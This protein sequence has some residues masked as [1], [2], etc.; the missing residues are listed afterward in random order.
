MHEIVARMAHAQ[1]VD[2]PTS[3]PME[4]L[5]LFRNATDL[6]AYA[7]GDVIF[8]VGE[9]GDRMYVVIEGEVDVVSGSRTI[10]TTGPGG[11]LGELALIDRSP[12]SAT[13][14]ARTACRLVPIDEKRFEFLVGQTPF[15]ALHVMRV[16]C[17]RLRR[18]TP[19]SDA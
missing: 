7:A 5:G 13:A 16:M 14:I 11:L 8:S 10:E 19:A 3:S 2:V 15:F 17:E 9:P 18:W 1:R 4:S 12:R 6:V